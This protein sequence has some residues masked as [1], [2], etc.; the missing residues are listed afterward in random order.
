[1]IA[2]IHCQ[3]GH[4]AAMSQE[5]KVSALFA[6]SSRS[7][8]SCR[9]RRPLPGRRIAQQFCREGTFY[10]QLA[11]QADPARA[12]ARHQ[13]DTELRPEIKRVWDENY[14]VYGVRK[15]WHQLKREGFPNFDS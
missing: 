4:C 6:A 8:E 14:Q 2:F 7:A 1:M 12:S 5:G 11:C 3:A 13:R 10:H 15:A 9:S